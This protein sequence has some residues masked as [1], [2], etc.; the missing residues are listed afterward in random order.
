MPLW[1]TGRGTAKG[2]RRRRRDAAMGGQRRAEAGA[3]G[4]M[5]GWKGGW[6]GE[7][8]EGKRKKRMSKS[9]GDEEPK[10]KEIEQREQIVIPEGWKGG[11]MDG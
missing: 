5:D 7:G 2:K 3:A 6:M 11:W 8:G 10:K 4:R 1:V 9:K